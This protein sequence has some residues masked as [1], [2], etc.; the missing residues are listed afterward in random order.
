[1]ADEFD[2]DLEEALTRYSQEMHDYTLQLWTDSRRV[3][4]GSKAA[5]TGGGRK[6]TAPAKG[7]AHDEGRSSSGTR[8]ESSSSSSSPASP[9]PRGR[10]T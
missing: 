9:K 4:E 7:P 8:P 10:P 3:A 5:K 2:K 1:M 6:K